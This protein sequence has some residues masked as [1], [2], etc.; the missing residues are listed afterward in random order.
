MA[1]I[2]VLELGHPIAAFWRARLT[3][4]TETRAPKGITS[5]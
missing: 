1:H 2:I 5:L 3:Q 4:R